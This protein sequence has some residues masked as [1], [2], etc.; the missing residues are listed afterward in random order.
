M[1][2]LAKN[3]SRAGRAEEVE[4]RRVATDKKVN[5]PFQI[6]AEVSF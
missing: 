6:F 5:R 1:Y 4:E 2:I 3:C